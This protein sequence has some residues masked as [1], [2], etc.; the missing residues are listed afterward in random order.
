LS[1]IAA[2]LMGERKA[3]LR[4]ELVESSAALSFAGLS[5]LVLQPKESLAI[6]NGT[7]IM[8]GR[9]CLAFARADNIPRAASLLTAAV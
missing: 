3:W 7:S 2:L 5:P 6:M 8:A 1:Y 9:T 4:G